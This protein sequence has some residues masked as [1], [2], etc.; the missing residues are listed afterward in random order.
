[1]IIS[2]KR[3]QM[4]QTQNAN[5]WQKPNDQHNAFTC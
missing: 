2:T 1:M 3:Y 5:A 4:P